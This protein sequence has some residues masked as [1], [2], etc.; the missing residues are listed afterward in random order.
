MSQERLII[1]SADPGEPAELM[2]RFLNFLVDS[3]L[4]DL[5][6]SLGQALGQGIED[7]ARDKREGRLGAVRRPVRLSRE[8]GDAT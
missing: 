2:D 7:W 5:F 1:H 4:P 6:N 3:G 8:E